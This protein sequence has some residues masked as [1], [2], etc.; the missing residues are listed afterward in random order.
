MSEFVRL[1][2]D[3]VVAKESIKYMRVEGVTIKVYL[4]DDD[5]L[6]L[7]Y[8]SDELAHKAFA[9]FAEMLIYNRV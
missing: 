8:D 7:L 2:R 5:T 4:S 6:G 3:T 9:G 1:G